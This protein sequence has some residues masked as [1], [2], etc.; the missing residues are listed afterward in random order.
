VLYVNP[1]SAGPRRFRLP[2]G[3]ATLSIAGQRVDAELVALD[4][5]AAAVTRASR[6]AEPRRL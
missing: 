1:G 5:D 4:V 6:A 2:V 3:V